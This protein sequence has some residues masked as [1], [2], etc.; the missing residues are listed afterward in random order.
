MDTTVEK[1]KAGRPAKV[2][3]AV[4][5]AT[6]EA[7]QPKADRIPATI[8]GYRVADGFAWIT[9]FPNAQDGGRKVFTGPWRV[10]DGEQFEFA[11][12]TSVCLPMAVI[13]NIIDSTVFIPEDEIDL[14][15]R[16]DPKRNKYA[17]FTRFP[18]S[19]PIPATY[20]EFMAFRQSQ[21]KKIHPNEYARK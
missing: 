19:D 12:G 2:K 6:V 16:S 15:G 9:I 13:N 4:V 10:G 1:R 7:P 18:H 17:P 8:L 14:A 20:H 3:P 11:K 5:P 21:A